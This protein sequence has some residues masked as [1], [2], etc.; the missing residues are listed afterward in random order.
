MRLT[1]L[2]RTRKARILLKLLT[3]ETAP[4]VSLNK[5]R[6]ADLSTWTDNELQA[7]YERLRQKAYR[8]TGILPPSMPEFSI[9]SDD[10]LRRYEAEHPKAICYNHEPNR[11]D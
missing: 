11:K 10:E 9:M 7:E 2:N 8:E 4:L 5:S 3:G 1:A 6:S